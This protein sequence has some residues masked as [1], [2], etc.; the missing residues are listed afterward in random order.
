[1]NRVGLDYVKKKIVEDH[2]GRKALWEQ[3]QFAL[4]GEPDP[5]FD[6]KEAEVDTRQFAPV[7]A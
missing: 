3:L 1:V 6:F 5:W 7:N 2:A 4:D